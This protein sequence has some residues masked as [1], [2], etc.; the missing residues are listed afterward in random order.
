LLIEFFNADNQ[1]VP[2][3]ILTS[4]EKYKDLDWKYVEVELKPRFMF[5]NEEKQTTSVVKKTLN[6]IYNEVFEL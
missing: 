2:K 3:E 4:N 5:P 1:G 6:P